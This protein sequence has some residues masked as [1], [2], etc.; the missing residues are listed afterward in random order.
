MLISPFTGL[1]GKY[2]KRVIRIILMYLKN[3]ASD[4]RVS[5]QNIFGIAPK[6]KGRGI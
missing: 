4:Q 1:K 3:P 6:F 2:A 5:P